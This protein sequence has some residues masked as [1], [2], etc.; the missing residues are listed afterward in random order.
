MSQFI[1]RE[2][3]YGK[4]KSLA[5]CCASLGPCWEWK[6]HSDPL[7][8][9]M[10]SQGNLYEYLQ[11]FPPMAK[12]FSSCKVRRPG[13]NN[14]RNTMHYSHACK[15]YGM[16]RLR[17]RR[18]QCLSRRAPKQFRWPAGRDPH[19]KPRVTQQHQGGPSK[20]LLCLLPFNQ[21]V[22]PVESNA[23]SRGHLQEAAFLSKA[24]A[25]LLEC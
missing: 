10:P 18:Q 12:V 14:Q 9:T 21:L 17:C 19:H 25:L 20:A 8:L 23:A 7:F 24:E 6:Y 5:L 3:R 16:R 13:R 15:Q 11:G 4:V 2:L 22:W 1:Q